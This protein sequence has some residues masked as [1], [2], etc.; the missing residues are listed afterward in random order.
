MLF[1]NCLNT[2]KYM[3]LHFLW[4]KI[5]ILISLTFTLKYSKNTHN[6]ESKHNV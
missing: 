5:R 2:K 1:K 6:H 4:L 3:N